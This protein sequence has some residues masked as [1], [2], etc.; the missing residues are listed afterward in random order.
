MS[1]ADRDGLIWLNGKLVDWSDAKLPLLSHGVHY[2]SAVFEGIRAYNGGVFKLTEHSQR[3]LDSGEIMDMTIPYSAAELDDICYKV[4]EAN[5]LTD[6][7]IRPIAW[8]GSEQMGVSAQEAKINVAVAAWEW[9]SYFSPE[10]RDKGI[11]LKTSKWRR[12]PPDSAPVHSKATGL[13]MICTLAKHEAEAAGYE[14]AL[15][16]DYRGYAAEATGANLFVMKDGV[17]HTPTPD[18]FL[19]GI[20][21]QTVIEL[22]KKEGYE[23]VV[24][25]IM[26]DELITAD[27]I[28][29]TG[30]AAEVTAIGRIDENTYE[31]GPITRK[32]REKYENLVRL[33]PALKQKAV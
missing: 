16:H 7:Y 31:V 13:Y 21:R 18:C 11:S 22:A 3:L 30:T 20:T 19:N 29:I 6:A 9:P 26:P 33:P 23:V 32:L 12:P 28:F 5:G 27:E 15:M 14:D 8:R 4:L 1:F 25:H 17:I 24:R 10:L 2:G